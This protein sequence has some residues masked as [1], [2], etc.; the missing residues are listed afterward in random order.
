MVSSQSSSNSLTVL[1]AEVQHPAVVYLASLSSGSRQTV[2]HSL[3]SVATF[4]GYED[5]LSVPWCRLRFQ[6]MQALR[7]WLIEKYAPTTARKIL[8]FVRGVL[9]TCRRLNLMTADTYLN[10]TDIPPIKGEMPKVGRLVP[11]DDL[12]KLLT[13]CAADPRPAGFRDAAIIAVLAT[14]GIRRGELAAL[15]LAAYKRDDHTLLIT[16]TKTKRPREVPLLGNAERLV[17]E[18]LEYRNPHGEHLFQAITGH[19]RVTP[20]KMTPNTVLDILA[21][22]ALQAGIPK[23]TPHDLRRTII[24]NLLASGVD[25]GTIQNLSGHQNIDTLLSYDRRGHE[26]LQAAVAEHVFIPYIEREVTRD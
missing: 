1:D 18:W 7:Q 9:L 4:L 20:R 15:A 5:Y 25:L 23:L 24:S 17:K 26:A 16:K 21:R 3:G 22:R 8:A 13:V 12:T 14:T 19:G 2:Q 6:H 10:A 11:L